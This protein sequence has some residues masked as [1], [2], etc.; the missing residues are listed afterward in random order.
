MSQEGESHMRVCKTCRK[1]L[2]RRD[3]MTEL[4]N[5]KP[6]LVQIYDVSM[7]ILYL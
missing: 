5:T 4:R 6:P 1:L 2:E 7:F 3:I